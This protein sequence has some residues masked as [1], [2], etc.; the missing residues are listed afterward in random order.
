M[1]KTKLKETSYLQVTEENNKDM[2]ALTLVLGGAAAYLLLSG[3]KKDIMQILQPAIK[4]EKYIKPFSV[5]IVQQGYLE[6]SNS[7]NKTIDILKLV[8]S[9]TNEQLT[10]SPVK[11]V[12]LSD[13]T[14]N[15]NSVLAVSVK[16][17][18]Q[19]VSSLQIPPHS[20][21]RLDVQITSVQYAPAGAA[22]VVTTD[23]DRFPFE[24]MFN[25]DVTTSSGTYS[26]VVG[27]I[28]SNVTDAGN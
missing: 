14:D 1:L 19:N 17:Q 18:G 3:R 23:F 4:L 6:L 2:K 16:Y 5:G 9:P 25:L 22:L 28:Y 24:A 13:F 11:T 26:T 7:T 21:V 20:T 10:Q 27:A 8:M 15:I 12:Y